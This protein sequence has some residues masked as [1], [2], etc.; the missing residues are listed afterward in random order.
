[1][2]NVSWPVL[3]VSEAPLLQTHPTMVV[4]QCMIN[5]LPQGIMAPDAQGTTATSQE[6]VA[7]GVDKLPART[8]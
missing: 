8:T 4:R 2:I 1:M 6:M 5:N 7:K 3:A